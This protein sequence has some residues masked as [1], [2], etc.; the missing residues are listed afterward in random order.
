MEMKYAAKIALPAAI[1]AGLSLF[2]VMPSRADTLSFANTP[3]SNAVAELNRRLGIT[4]VFRGGVSAN[5]PVTFSVDNPDTPDGRLEAVSALANALGL[6]FQKVFVVSKIDAGATVP[7]VKIDSN[8]PIVF[9]SG[10]MSAREAIQTVAAVD[11]AVTQ[12]SS[13]ITGDVVFPSRRVRAVEA[14]MLIAKQTQ[15]G[16]KS[17]YGLF[18]RGQG[19]QRL[20]GTVLD[21]TSGGQAITELPL[22]T[23]RNTISTPA[24]TEIAGVKPAPTALPGVGP[25][26]AVVPA[27]DPYSYS[28][29]GF[30]P[31][32]YSPYGNGGYSPYGGYGNGGY[33]NGGYSPYGG[34]GGYPTPSGPIYPGYDY[35][36]TGTG[37]VGTGSGPTVTPVPNTNG[38]QILPDFPYA[39]GMS[40][41]YLIGGY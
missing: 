17:Y 15:T 31:Y 9:P 11:N 2:T 33:G 35:S 13:A 20:E 25:N 1:L 41:Q 34:Y 7:E 27:N 19:P 10:K 40:G 18:R 21:H 22:M 16:W 24:P 32:A 4:I 14:A 28:P 23:Y 5:Q 37:P 8:A 12:I 26:V 38:G 29:Y 6:D 30:N 3:A 39:G 36:P